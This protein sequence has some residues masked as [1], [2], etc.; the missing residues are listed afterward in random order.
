M[1]RPLR[2]LYPGSLM[3]RRRHRTWMFAMTLATFGAGVWGAAL[4]WRRLSPETAPTLEQTFLASSAFAVPG[5]LLAFLTL[6]ARLVWLLLAGVPLFANGML[7]VLPWL[8]LHL[9][10]GG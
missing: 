1:A 9:R 4:L 8:A 6:R 2:K 3:V 5:F 7:L 10:H